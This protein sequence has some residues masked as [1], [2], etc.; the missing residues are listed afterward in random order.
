MAFAKA[1]LQQLFSWCPLNQQASPAT[2]DRQQDI[3]TTATTA[4]SN[5][6]AKQHRQMGRTVQQTTIPDTRH[7]EPWRQSELRDA[8]SRNDATR[9][10]HLT[11]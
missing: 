6:L 2:V 11:R 1:T 5:R 10:E 3:A 9:Y 4:A 7:C 8:A